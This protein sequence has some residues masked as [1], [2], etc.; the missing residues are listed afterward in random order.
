MINALKDLENLTTIP[1]DKLKKLANKLEW[2]IVDSLAEDHDKVIDIDIGIG[3][4]QLI[5]S[6]R[7]EYRFIPSAS[8]EKAIKKYFEDNVNILENT[9]EKTLA[10]RIINTYKDIL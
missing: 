3:T 2:I 1:E 9:L 6:D 4:L 10:S 5:D 8:L 7:L